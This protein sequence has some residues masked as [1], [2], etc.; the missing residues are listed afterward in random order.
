MSKDDLANVDNLEV[1][2]LSDKELDSVAGG[3]VAEGTDV[4]SCTCCAEGAITHVHVDN[5]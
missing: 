4:A 3:N 2:A 5:S 1:E